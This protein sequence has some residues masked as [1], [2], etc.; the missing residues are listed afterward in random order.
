MKKAIKLCGLI[1]LT[2]AIIPLLAGAV[3]AYDI[4]IDTEKGVLGF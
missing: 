2:I 4:I 1:V 3:S